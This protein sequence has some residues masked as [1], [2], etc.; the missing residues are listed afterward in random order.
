MSMILV[1]Q[2]M[3]SLFFDVTDEAIREDYASVRMLMNLLE[4]SPCSLA[5]TDA[6][7]K[8]LVF[9]NRSFEEQTG[10]KSEEVIGKNSNLLQVHALLL[11]LQFG[12]SLL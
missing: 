10:Y 4:D 2:Q 9:V 12:D 5:V 8:H 7:N 1:L 3:S 11:Y 6:D